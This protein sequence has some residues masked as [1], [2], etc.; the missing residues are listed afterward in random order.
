MDV[1]DQDC[2]ID[3][4]WFGVTWL[5]DLPHIWCHTGAY[6]IT[7]EIRRFSW[8]CA[9]I[10]TY[11]THTKMLTCSLPYHETSVN[12]LWIHLVGPSFFDIWFPAWYLFRE[13][14]PRYMDLIYIT[15]ITCSMID[16]FMSS[17]FQP[18]VHLMP[19]WGIFPFWVRFT[20]LHGV[21]WSPP[22]TGFA[23]RRWRAHYFYEDFS[24]E[25][26]GSHPVKP[27]LLGT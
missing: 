2:I 13:T 4:W 20:N 25:P 11:W 23:P 17:N 6:S 1:D 5:S 3:D 27:A 24:V 21:V 22:L 10:I 26:L 19:Y 15:E 9:I 7:V 18:I 12:P 14:F 16:G 8:S